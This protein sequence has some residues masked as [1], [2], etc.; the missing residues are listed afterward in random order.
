MTKLTAI[1]KIPAV[2]LNKKH[3]HTAKMIAAK[4]HKTSKYFQISLKKSVIK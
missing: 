3:P 1:L 2:K 4:K